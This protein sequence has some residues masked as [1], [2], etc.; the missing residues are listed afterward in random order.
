MNSPASIV[1]GIVCF[2]L[3]VVWP[4]KRMWSLRVCVACTSGQGLLRASRNSQVQSEDKQRSP[5]S[6]EGASREWDGSLD[7]TLT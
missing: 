5:M 6:K 1:T 2:A 3:D 7:T 4:G